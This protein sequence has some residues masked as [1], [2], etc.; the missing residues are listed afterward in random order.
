MHLG[1]LVRA[2]AKLWHLRSFFGIV[3]EKGERE[4]N[5]GRNGSEKT[6]SNRMFGMYDSLFCNSWLH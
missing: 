3:S 5:E 2:A 6:L 1:F 4:E